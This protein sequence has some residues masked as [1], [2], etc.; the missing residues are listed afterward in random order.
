MTFYNPVKEKYNQHKPVMSAM[1]RMANPMLA[2][3]EVR[4]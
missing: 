1:V 2:E 3:I 4:A